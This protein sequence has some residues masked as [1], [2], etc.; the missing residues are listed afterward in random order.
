MRLFRTLLLMLPVLL[1]AGTAQATQ[2]T[3][4]QATIPGWQHSN[5]SPQLRI[6]LSKPVVTSG[7][8]VLQSGS[9]QSG[10]FYQS[11]ACSV[12]GG[13]LTIPQLTIDSLTDALVG[14]DAR[15]SAYFY[16]SSGQQIA[17]YQGFTSFSVPSAP[18]STTW[19]AILT[20][21]STSIPFNDLFTYSRTQI[22]GLLASAAGIADPGAGG[23]VV[24]SALNTSV[25]R[26]IA[27]GPN[28]SVANA[29][30]VS[31]NPTV[32]LGTS[33]VTSVI[34]DTNIQGSITNN[35]LTLS[36]TS[37]LAKAR[38]HAATVYTDQANTY[39]GG[40]K[41]IFQ[42]SA[43]T[44]GLN[45]ATS[46][47]PSTPTQGDL[48]LNASTLKYRGASASFNLVTETRAINTTGPITGGGDLSTNRTIACATCLTSSS[49]VTVAQGGTGVGSFTANGVPYGNGTGALQ[50]TAQGGANSVLTAN[51]SAPVFSATPTVDRV[52]AN[53]ASVTYDQFSNALGFGYAFASA[54]P[55][56]PVTI[57]IPSG[58]ILTPYIVSATNSGEGKLLAYYF[59]LTATGS[60]Q[61]IEPIRGLYG[62]LTNAGNQKTSAIR[63]GVT[64]S[65]SSTALLIAADLDITPAAGTNNA[66]TV[67][68]ATVEG[69]TDDVG[70]AL[71]IYPGASNPRYSQGV[72]SIAPIKINAAFYR[73]WM[74][75]GSNA[76]A[77]GFQQLNNAGTE[78][79]Y[80]DL[81]GNIISAGIASLGTSPAQ[82]GQVRLPN[83]A[84]ISARN[85]GNSA[86]VSLM[87]LNT[88]NEIEVGA[89]VISQIANAYFQVGPTSSGYLFQYIDAD[90]RL[91]FFK[92]GVGEFV[93]ISAAGVTNLFKGADVASATSVTP[94]GNT[95][96]ITGTATVS[97]IS[98]TGLSAGTVLTMITAS[99]G[100]IFDEAGNIDIT[101]ATSLT[102]TADGLVIAVW[103][104]SKWRM[105]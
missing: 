3:V 29:D 102:S 13:V 45:L 42:N 55:G 91:R 97:T 7:N 104:G 15:Y 33:V 53:P 4:Q 44:A 95:F 77:R 69:T 23:I 66:S 48:W 87:K 71:L 50:V 10:T 54:D 57:N 43:A 82:S 14:A 46:A 39:T 11:F 6:F 56:S 83:N 85:P 62:R 68:G 26:S 80:T 75:A 47:D 67:F 64:G 89:G 79:F 21:N 92:H 38:Q 18:T 31:G 37:T 73:A 25:S 35:A 28:L 94:T 88:A 70:S 81:S 100:L 105:R 1:L 27:V 84:S 78:L 72:G 60:T 90:G 16:T 8:V 103:D 32:S 58:K 86:D 17:S 12:T 20:F 34:N 93:S 30:G 2:I 5:T 98:A 101:N 52:R 65:G 96:T 9:T 41:Q 59:N 61:D 49:L 99:A 19:A 76:N 74:G 63:V 51:G 24:R 22:N 40:A 36:W